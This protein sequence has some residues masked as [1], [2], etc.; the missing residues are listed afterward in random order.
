VLPV[1]DC[2]VVSLEIPVFV[3]AGVEVLP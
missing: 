3:L 2:D 1:V